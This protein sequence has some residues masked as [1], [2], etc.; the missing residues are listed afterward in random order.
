MRTCM[1]ELSHGRV[2]GAD[3]DALVPQDRVPTGWQ[4]VGDGGSNFH[5]ET[6]T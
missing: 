4:Q 3:V 6:G 2:G 1:W 5:L